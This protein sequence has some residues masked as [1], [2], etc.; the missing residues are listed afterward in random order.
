[1]SRARQRGSTRTGVVF[2][3]LLVGVAGLG[4]YLWHGGLLP[5]RLR[6]DGIYAGNSVPEPKGEL[7]VPS[8]PKAGYVPIVKVID[9]DTIDVTRN[10]QRER[11]RLIGIDCP[12]SVT[13][14]GKQATHFVLG[15]LRDNPQ[16]RLE[17][18]KE[19][20]D[21][22]DRTLAYV[23]LASGEMLNEV[24]L[25]Q[26]WAKVMTIAPNTAHR[27]RFALAQETAQQQQ[28]GLWKK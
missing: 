16:V 25:Q 18:D 1:M 4:V 10:G 22:Y 19:R 20:K 24:I 23:Y 28:K 3:V 17:F 7:G 27:N 5:F 2:A 11:I 8:D 13:E 6:P 9:G 15:L 26:G 14:E 12:E 21:K